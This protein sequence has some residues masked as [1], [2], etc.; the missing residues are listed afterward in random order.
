MGR[1][2]YFLFDLSGGLFV[3]ERVTGRMLFSFFVCLLFK[4]VHF[5]A[6]FLN[7]QRYSIQYLI[8]WSFKA[9]GQRK[10]KLKVLS[11][12]EFP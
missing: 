11:H 4:T 5:L 2:K 7:F 12:C 1:R 8:V 9:K 10:S 6:I 3:K